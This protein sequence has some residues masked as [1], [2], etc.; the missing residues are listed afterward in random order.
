MCPG[1]RRTFLLQHPQNVE[2]TD[3]FAHEHAIGALLPFIRTY[4]PS[5]DIVPIAISLWSTRD[6]WDALVRELT[7]IVDD[8]TLVV[9]SSDFSHYLP[10]GQAARRD[11]E[12]L[13][14][15]AAHDY[16]ETATLS[17]PNNI[18]SKGAQYIQERI[19]KVRF[20]ADPNAIFNMNSQQFLRETVPRTTSYIVEIYQRPAEAKVAMAVPGSRVY[21][22]VGDTFFGR[23]VDRVTRGQSGRMLL[24]EIR[25]A[26]NGCRL[27][28]NFEGAISER[29][30]DKPLAPLILISAGATTADWLKGLNVFGASLANNHA[31]DCGS[32]GFQRTKAALEQD[33]VMVSTQNSVADFGDFRLIAVT[34]GD[35]A[36]RRQSGLLD[37][38]WTA[39]TSFAEVRGPL[40]AFVNWGDEY[41]K[42]S[43][44]REDDLKSMLFRKGVDLVIGVHPHFAAAALNLEGGIRGLSVFSLGNFIFDQDRR[45]SSSALLE[46][47]VFDQRTFFVRTVGM[48]NWFQEG[49]NGRATGR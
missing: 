32:S 13:N 41:A 4:L 38:S 21:C 45:V 9:Q 16:A 49:L 26:T 5:A 12:T 11:Q 22:F 7:L 33:G 43:S 40:F 19:Q 37:A 3:L 17:Q 23:G 31:Y 36:I 28:I 29:L 25:A 30:P 47:R 2:E 42:D 6:D 1:R 14:I 15:L 46:I 39:L 35:N 8:N 18:N 27:Y 10:A 24:S 20:N 34:D 44:A 48:K